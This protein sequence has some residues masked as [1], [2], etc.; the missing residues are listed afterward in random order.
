MPIETCETCGSVL[1]KRVRKKRRFCN[2]ECWRLKA[3]GPRAVNKNGKPKAIRG[4]HTRIR[5]LHPIPPDGMEV[6]WS[7]GLVSDCGAPTHSVEAFLNW[8]EDWKIR[9]AEDKV[10]KVCQ[11]ILSKVIAPRKRS[12]KQAWLRPE[13]K[14]MARLRSRTPAAR[15]RYNRYIKNRMATDPDFK[16]RRYLRKRLRQALIECK[17]SKS[18]S[19]LKLVGCSL[20]ELRDHLKSQFE[21]GMS[22]ANYG[23]W[24]VD[25]KIPCAKFDLTKPEEQARCF[26]YLN[27]QPLW[28]AVNIGKKDRIAAPSQ[29][30]L[31]I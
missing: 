21:H 18:A 6:R 28:A 13:V 16:L 17:G 10:A 15:A 5:E 20:E 3:I 31:G 1:P 22:W 14:A 23:R 27:L 11:R 12:A 2:K 9:R 19:A 7:Q 24:H 4:F 26:H 8:L 29:I 30:P 25:H